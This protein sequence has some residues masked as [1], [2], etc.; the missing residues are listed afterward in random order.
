VRRVF[1]FVRD[2]VL[3]AT[4]KRQ[5]PFTYGSLPGERISSSSP[6][7]RAGRERLRSA[8]KG[9]ILQF[10]REWWNTSLAGSSCNGI[11]VGEAVHIVRHA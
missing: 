8:G 1:D 10:R 5:Q 6:R 11:V 2:D 9:G 3:R 4:D 7:S